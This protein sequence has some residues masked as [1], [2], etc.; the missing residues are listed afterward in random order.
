[1]AKPKKIK[2]GLSGGDGVRYRGCP[3]TQGLPFADGEF[4]SSFGARVVDRGGRPKPTQIA[5][6]ATWNRDLKYVRWLLLDFQ[7]DLEPGN[8][9]ELFLEYGPDVRPPECETPVRVEEEADR[10]RFDTGPMQLDLGP[11][12]ERRGGSSLAPVPAGRLFMQS[13]IRANGEWRDV[14]PGES[15]PFLY[16]EDQHGKFYD[17]LAPGPPGRIVVEEAGPLRACVC[18]KGYHTAQDGSRFCPFIL[19]IHLFGGKSELRIHHTFIYDQDPNTVE[20]ASIGMRFPFDLGVVERARSTKRF[21]DSDRTTPWGMAGDSQGSALA[22][23]RNGWQE[24]PK[25]VETEREGMDVQIWPRDCGETL[26]FTT[27]FEEEAVYF[28]HTR[29]QE[30]VKRLLAEKPGAPLNLKSF[31]IND[32]DALEWMER[33]VEEYAPGRAVSHNDTSRDNGTGAAKTTEL[34][35]RLEAKPIEDSEA[36]AFAGTVQEPLIAPAEPSHTCATGAFGHFY[37]AGDPR[38]EK[39]DEGLNLIVDQ[40][41]A[42]PIEVCRLYGMMRYGNAVC[43]HSPSPGVTYVHYKDKN[44]EKALQWVG[45]YN[46][47]ANDQ[48]MGV[49]G[50]FIRTGRRDHYFL[51]QDYSRSVAD[52][53]FIHAHPYRPQ[54]VGLMHYH[55]ATQWSGGPSPSHSLLSG[56]LADYYF[57]GNRRLLEVAES[58]ADWAVRWQKP[59]GILHCDQ[60]NHREF[61]GPLWSL[62]EVY[63]AT[64]KEKYGDVA[65]RSLNWFLRALP[66]PGGYHSNLFTCGTLGDEAV[67]GPAEGPLGHARDLYVIY[68]IAL[69]LFD[70][71]TLREHVLAEADYYVRE[72]LTDHYVSAD[73][74]RRKLNPGAEVW[75]VDDGF[76]YFRWGGEIPRYNMTMVCLAYELTK[77]PV[78]AS[79]AKDQFEGCFLR[80]VK[81]WRR[82]AHFRFANISQGSIIPRFMRIAADAMDRNPEGLASADREW[83]RRRE[84]SGNPVYAGPGVDL[85]E[86]TMSPGGTITNRPPVDIPC[87]KPRKRWEPLTSLGR[88][89]TEDH[90]P[91]N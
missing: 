74:A 64:W 46:N 16:V 30:T 10:L 66:G 88:L 35:L 19:R 47:E 5:P 84:E 49:W 17:T 8:H 3:V 77:D 51:A 40:V 38:F 70:S 32:P 7:A 24:Y 22:V 79:Y 41:L 52:V 85:E 57:S 78:Y 15:S 43:A 45:P 60:T 53:G 59:C 12:G 72:G 21:D 54:A 91:P 26:K 44:P 34:W 65:R 56:I 58:C 14:F 63:Q 23:I 29:D 33:M 83:R 28:G 27:G 76:Y 42:E 31:N 67:V 25:A 4:D 48:I 36:E 2:L 87:E 1:M 62:L 71:R 11:R 55:N 86:D 69:R 90:P 13:R 20:L 6:L 89:S 75:P 18:V 80:R 68:E 81:L 82:F 73:Q 37:H 50:N 9:E 39:V 61:T